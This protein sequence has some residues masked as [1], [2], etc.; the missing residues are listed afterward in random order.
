MAIRKNIVLRLIVIVAI[1]LAVLL[2]LAPVFLNID[3]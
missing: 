3:R 1:V 2:L